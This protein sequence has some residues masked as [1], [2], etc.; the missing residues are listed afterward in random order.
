[1][2]QSTT[3]KV[4][5]PRCQKTTEDSARRPVE[6]WMIEDNH[7][8]RNTVARLLNQTQDIALHAAFSRV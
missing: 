7:A 1:M 2:E 8:F 4:P 3:K 6:V 5:T